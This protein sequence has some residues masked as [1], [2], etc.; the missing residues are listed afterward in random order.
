MNRRQR[1]SVKLHAFLTSALRGSHGHIHAP[2]TF[3][4]LHGAEFF[5]R[6]LVAQ[7]LKFPASCGI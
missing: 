1:V 7:F 6:L 4:E 3:H 2:T 5:L